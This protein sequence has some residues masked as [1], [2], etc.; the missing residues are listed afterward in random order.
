M[1]FLVLRF[2]V[3]ARR[4]R[5]SS[6]A[7]EMEGRKEKEGRKRLVRAKTAAAKGSV[8]EN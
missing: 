1:A 4:H 5:F 2:Y 3:L 6:V 8:D 7:L